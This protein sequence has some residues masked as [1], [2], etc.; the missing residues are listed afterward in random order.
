LLRN[1]GSAELVSAVCAHSK[2]SLPREIRIALLRNEHTAL[3]HAVEFA[4]SLPN[5]LVAEILQNSKLPENV[6][7]SLTQL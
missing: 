7:A 4:K 3:E 1:E 2:W 6:R 5:D